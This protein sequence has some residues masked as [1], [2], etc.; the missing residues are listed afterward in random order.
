MIEK[1]PSMPN[2]PKIILHVAGHDFNPVYDQ[3]AALV[4][5]LGNEYWCHRAESLAA[6]E[7]LGECDL[8]VFLGMYFSGWEGR[9]RAPGE[10]HKRALERYITSGR[11]VVLCHGAIVS[12]DDWPRFGQLVG[13][14]W[15]AGVR[16]F[17]PAGDY[18]VR[19][20]ASPHPLIR[21][22]EDYTVHCAPPFDV[23]VAADMQT[24]EHAHLE[25]ESVA[26]PVMMTGRGGRVG[27]AGKSVYIAHGHDQR[28][29]ENEMV[30]R[31]W[32]NTVE[33]CLTGA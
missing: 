23:Q 16:S 11:P 8:L 27:G 14:S 4:G 20:S 17:A 32:L 3:A 19:L 7:H 30:R 10:V 28:S 29:F 22:M 1:R 21:G 33:W 5:W 15:P 9:Y 18:A 24:T 6:F 25:W 12:Y 31:L 13:F 26:R 2:R